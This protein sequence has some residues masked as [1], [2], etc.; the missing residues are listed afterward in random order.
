M[1]WGRW[2]TFLVLPSSLVWYSWP[3][4]LIFSKWLQAFPSGVCL[5]SLFTPSG[6]FSVPTS[7]P[8]LSLSC[9]TY[10]FFSFRT[11]FPWTCPNSI[12]LSTMPPYH[13]MALF[14]IGSVLSSGL[15]APWGVVIYTF[16]PSEFT[17]VFIRGP[18]NLCYWRMKW[19][20]LKEGSPWSM[21]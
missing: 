7:T 18:I 2:P 4:E 1:L 17:R 10:S 12:G 21:P 13:A 15:R 11:T 5:T 16:R 3:S 9:Q 6:L 8:C 19:G 20:V 14:Y